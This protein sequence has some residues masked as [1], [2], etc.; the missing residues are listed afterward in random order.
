MVFLEF[1]ES[2][3]HEDAMKVLEGLVPIFRAIPGAG[4]YVYGPNVSPEGLQ[5][6]YGYAFSMDFDSVESRDLY[7]ESADHQTFARDVIFPALKRGTDSVAVL[8]ITDQHQ[9]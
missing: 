6:V 7:L 3:S 5:Q 8:D 1:D 2:R 4:E 9:H